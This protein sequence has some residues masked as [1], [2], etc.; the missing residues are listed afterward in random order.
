M[1]IFEGKIL[2][3]I[4]EKCLLERCKGDFSWR[5]NKVNGLHSNLHNYLRLS[6]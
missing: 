6:D 3:E 5:L 2:R 1:A 4:F